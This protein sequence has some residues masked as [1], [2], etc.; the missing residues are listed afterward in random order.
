MRNMVRKKTQIFDKLG[1]IYL[2]NSIKLF[3]LIVSNIID[4]HTTLPKHQNS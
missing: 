2:N 4:I 3:L 1:Q